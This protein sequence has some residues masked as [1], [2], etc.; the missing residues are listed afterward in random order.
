MR[1]VEKA[2]KSQIKVQKSMCAELCNKKAVH[3]DHTNL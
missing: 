1:R 2:A 3:R